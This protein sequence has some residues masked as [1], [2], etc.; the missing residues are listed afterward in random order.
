MPQKMVYSVKYSPANKKL[1]V[2]G[3]YSYASFFRSNIA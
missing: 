1:L 3:A 2:M